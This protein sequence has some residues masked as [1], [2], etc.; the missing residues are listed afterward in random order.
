MPPAPVH[1][2]VVHPRENELVVATHGRGLHVIDVAPLQELAAAGGAK[3][4]LFAPRAVL[5]R[6]QVEARLPGAFE[7]AGSNPPDGAVLH[8]LL[9]E[10]AAQVRLEIVTRTGGVVATLPAAAGR[11]LH[12]VVWGLRGAWGKAVVPAPPGEY[13]VR[14][15]AGETVRERK[16]KIAAAP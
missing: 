3:V 5:P 11:G 9:R 10:P 1:D 4:H 7:F 12:R 16:L 13:R 6:K 15:V 2:L 8:Y 14:L